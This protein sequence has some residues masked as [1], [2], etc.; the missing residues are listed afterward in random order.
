MAPQNASTLTIASNY[1]QK[2]CQIYSKMS[3]KL[4]FCDS[5]VKISL[6][7]MLN[8]LGVD[9]IHSIALDF[10]VQV[11]NDYLLEVSQNAAA[12]CSNSNRKKLVYP[13]LLFLDFEVL[14]KWYSLLNEQSSQTICILINSIQQVILYYPHNTINLN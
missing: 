10:L 1:N 9:R 13:D 2:L 6:S 11:F 12:S 8:H 7:Q 14:L 4:E 5:L 3:H